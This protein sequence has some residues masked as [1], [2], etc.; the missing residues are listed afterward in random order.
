MTRS[1]RS[2]NGCFGSD[3]AGTTVSNHGKPRETG[4]MSG[5]D[6]EPVVPLPEQ[7]ADQMKDATDRL[8]EQAWMVAPMT[9]A[10]ADLTTEDREPAS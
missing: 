3:I 1:H 8:R 2:G 10:V 4:P 6:T 9:S 7:A 5:S